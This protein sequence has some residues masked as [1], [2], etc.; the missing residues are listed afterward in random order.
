MICWE[1]ESIFD[2]K[3]G[4]AANKS[5]LYSLVRRDEE[6]STSLLDKVAKL[7]KKSEQKR[8]I[9]CAIGFLLNNQ[10]SEYDEEY[11]N[12]DYDMSD[13]LSEVC[14]NEEQLCDILLDYCY[15][16]NGNK[17]ILWNVCGETIVKR[18][19]QDNTLCYPLAAHDGDFEVQGKKYRMKEY[20]FGGDEDE[21]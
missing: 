5:D 11:S 14:N 12:V 8:A 19:S 1:I 13:V 7:C 17:E 9:K 21:V 15:K 20:T 4:F 10:D 6:C 3:S 18:L 2:G 16:Y